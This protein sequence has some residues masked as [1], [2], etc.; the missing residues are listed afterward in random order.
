MTERNLLIAGLS[1]SRGTGAPIAKLVNHVRRG[2]RPRKERYL[3]RPL[4][5]L[6]GADPLEARPTLSSLNGS[7]GSRSTAVDDQA[8]AEVVRRDRHPHLVARQ[9]ADMVPAHSPRQLRAD[10]GAA[11]VH[12][13]RIL[14][15]AQGVLNHA[16][17]LE[18]ITFTHYCRYFPLKT[19]ARG[20]WH[21]PSQVASIGSPQVVAN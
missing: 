11:L 14:A 12:L 20:P 4:G 1:A 6:L 13:D 7:A 16:L 18:K 21:R 10:H 8:M 3:G 17:H 5:M 2:L 9:D 19:L 15:P